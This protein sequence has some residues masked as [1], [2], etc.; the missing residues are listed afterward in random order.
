MM[1]RRK[2]LTLILMVGILFTQ[3]IPHAA[4]AGTC[5]WA[6]FISDVTAAGNPSFLPGVPF[7]KTWRLQNIGT[8]TWSTSYNLVFHSG[9]R[10][11]APGSISL[12]RP[13]PPGGMVDISVK[14][15]SPMTGGQHDGMSAVGGAH[16]ADDHLDVL[17][18]GVIGDEQGPANLLVG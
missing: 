8:C 9:E 6:K 2:F 3:S 7:T 15:I 18:G 16:L 1:V 10:M 13:V 11:G 12:N 17:L 4:A 14:M 5:D